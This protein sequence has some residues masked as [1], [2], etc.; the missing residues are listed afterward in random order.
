[1]LE[2]SSF[3]VAFS[4]EIHP[5]QRS[6]SYI[7]MPRCTQE[8]RIKMYDYLHKEMRKRKGF[9]FHPIPQYG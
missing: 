3:R 9:K 5:G 8:E 7:S 1:M 2:P 6:R 4:Y